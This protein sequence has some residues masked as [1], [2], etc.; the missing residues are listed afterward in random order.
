[1]G[2]RMIGGSA[3]AQALGLYRPKPTY[4]PYNIASKLPLMSERQNSTSLAILEQAPALLASAL[5]EDL[6][7]SGA[8]GAGVSLYRGFKATMP[9]SEMAKQR[10]RRVRGGLADDEVGGTKMGL[11]RLGDKARGLLTEGDDERDLEGETKE[12]LGVGRKARRRR[13][14]RRGSV[15]H[16][17]GKEL[18]MEELAVQ[19]DEIGVDKDNLH[20]RRVG[21][22]ASRSPR[23]PR[24]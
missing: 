6:P 11:K 21:S 9:S 2:S 1:M 22:G 16:A 10:R 5:A 12:S 8:G 19:A 18:S 23:D 14:A 24:Y 7:D 17:A 20:V 4:I 13:K 3:S 15:G